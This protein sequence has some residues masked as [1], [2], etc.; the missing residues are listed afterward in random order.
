MNLPLLRA[1]LGWIDFSPTHRDRVG[2]ILDMLKPEGSIDE[3]GLGTIRDGLANQM[4]PGISTI[5]TRAKY[6]FIIP[7]IL[8]EY[9]Q[10]NK[11]KQPASKYLEQREN[12]IMWQLA[13]FYKHEE[14]LGVIGITKRYPNTI[15]RR[16]STIYWNGLRTFDFISTKGLALD[17]YL[18]QNFGT[19]DFESLLSNVND[20]DDQKDD[21]DAGYIQKTGVRV[22]Y[23][24]G[25]EKD[26]ILE[27]T[28]EESNFFSDRIKSIVKDKVMGQLL[29]DKDLWTLFKDAKNFNDFVYENYDKVKSANL[30]KILRLSHDFSELMFGAHLYYNVLI[31]KRAFE[32]S[33]F[34]EDWEDWKSNF[35]N[36]MLNFQ[37]FKPSE[38]LKFA[39]NTRPQ[40]QD[41][42]SKW[43]KLALEGFQDEKEIERLIIN[44]E[45]SAKG[46]KAR[47]FLGKYDDVQK[48]EWIGFKRFE[49]RFQNVKRILSD[50][51]NPIASVPS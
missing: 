11:K 40:T 20:G 51:K 36:K 19:K 23:Q 4:F 44:Q 13:E 17:A 16:A 7:Y 3:L 12:E 32:T 26:L 31:Q 9:Y 18:K 25:W 46:N 48:G 28:P 2:S 6:Y 35:G 30:Q 22:P 27:F 29:I 41:F 49:Y 45:H 21:I 37:D 43:Y 38:V 50:I 8:H 10:N 1:T 34:R 47:L 24:K 42:V 5:Q 39:P 14:G 15:A 33:D